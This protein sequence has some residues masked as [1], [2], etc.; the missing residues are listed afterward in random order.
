MTAPATDLER[1]VADLRSAFD[2]AFGEP[3]VNATASTEDLLAIRVAG[4]PYALVVSELTGVVSGRRVVSLPSRRAD[5]LGVAG[6]RGVVVPVYGLAGL[7]GYDAAGPTPAWL[8]LCGST[9]PVA[10]A[11]DKLEEFLRVPAADLHAADGTVDTTR[12]HVSRVARVA[13]VTRRVIDTRSTLA[14]LQIAAGTAG[15]KKDK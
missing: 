9:D 11:F 12:R 14:A 13:A 7:L 15:S 1:R 2:R 10:L 6:I 4:D 8:A 3:T 5:L